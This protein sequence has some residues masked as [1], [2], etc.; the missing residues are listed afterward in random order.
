[1]TPE[2]ESRGAELFAA[3]KTER[4]VAAEL[5]VGNA[6][7]HRLKLRLD[8]QD[9][10]DVP[11]ED[12]VLPTPEEDAAAVDAVLEE[13]AS[14]G[15]LAELTR[16]RDEITTALETQVAR[17]EA[18]ARAVNDLEQ[19]QTDH[20][21]AGLDASALRPRLRDARDDLADWAR[22]V[23]L[24]QQRLAEVDE[25]IAAWHASKELDRMRGELDAA[26][27]ERDAVFARTGERMRA[28]VLAVREAAQEFTAALS[29]EREAEA[30]A[31]QLAQAVGASVAAP[32]RTAISAPPGFDSGAPLALT[33]AIQEAYKGDVTAVARRLGEVNGW[34]P[35]GPPTP[36]ELEQFRKVA[37]DRERMVAEA[38]AAASRGPRAPEEPQVASVDH[39]GRP[40]DKFGN[41]LVPR[42]SLPHPL[43]VYRIPVA[44]NYDSGYRTGY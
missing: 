13:A 42:G 18:S 6:S 32:V 41:E 7:A 34:L 17:A 31:G 3:G 11:A 16:I 15:A 39:F 35:P 36:E 33:R 5:G 2:Q 44:G 30:R 40:F 26:V 43:D 9:Q 38:K 10:A 37:E 12:A 20:L 23:G 28:A 27:A 25:H 29:D 8:A 22:S 4:E 24:L 1:M 14:D 21:A 19:Q